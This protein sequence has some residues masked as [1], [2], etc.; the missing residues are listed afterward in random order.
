MLALL[1]G[2]TET[3]AQESF[4]WY[5][6]FKPNYFW[7]PSAGY[8]AGIG[9]NGRN[10][11]LDGDA[12][13][14]RHR[15]QQFRQSTSIGWATSKPQPGWTGWLVVTNVVRHLRE[16]FYGEG[17]G[18][19]VTSRQIIHR[20]RATAEVRR[21]QALG[22]SAWIQAAGGIRLDHVLNFHPDIPGSTLPVETTAELNRIE[23]AG[24]QAALQGSLDLG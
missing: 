14:S 6:I 5:P 17:P 12:G 13:R 10:L 7:A 24:V 9:L 18:A 3:S 8:G 15:I 22:G 20:N 23:A 21:S 1:W 2:I 19:L 16:E 11:F 4:Y